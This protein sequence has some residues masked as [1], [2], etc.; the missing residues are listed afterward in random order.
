MKIVAKIIGTARGRRAAMVPLVVVLS[1]FSDR[2]WGDEPSPANKSAHLVEPTPGKAATNPVRKNV[3]LPGLVVNFR[4]RCV[5]LESSVCLDQGFLEL[6]ACTKGSKEHESIV[7]IKA[8]PMHVH[9]AL[10][11]LGVHSGNPAMR[12][13]IDAQGTRWINIPP[14]GDPVRVSLVFKGGKGKMTEHSISDFIARSEDNADEELDADEDAEFP[15]T[16]LFAGSLLRGDGPG[17]R[18]YLADH[19]GNVISIATF[20]DE[21]LC[22][23]D[24]QSHQNGA[25]MWQVD[26]TELPEVGS[27]VTLRLRPQVQP[28]P[29]AGDTG[30]PPSPIGT[31]GK[32]RQ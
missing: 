5:D 16:F 6:I 30:L 29:K 7:A 31:S 22:L 23:P 21:L 2:S 19:S 9:T 3:K 20:G 10:L 12:R 14:K 8:K 25:L 15:N 32:G 13:P 18:K 4:E 24:V 17:P 28:V 27:K 1:V 26:A 11:L